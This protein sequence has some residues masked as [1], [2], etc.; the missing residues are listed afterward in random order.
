MLSTVIEISSSEED[1]IV[2]NLSKKPKVE[3]FTVHRVDGDGHCI[4]NC[5]V[6]FLKKDKNEILDILWN[7]FRENVNT[8]IQFGEYT[9]TNELLECLQEYVH[10]RKYNQ[11][12]VDLVLEALSKVFLLRIFIFEGSLNNDPLGVI[13]E[14][15]TKCIN[16]IKS[17]DH[18]NLVVSSTKTNDKRLVFMLIFVPYFYTFSG[19]L[20]QYTN[21][22]AV[23]RNLI[24]RAGVEIG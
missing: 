2:E 9:S 6:T 12:T 11:D 18:Y 4:I 10:N 20:Q 3:D 8:Y 22:H 17:G 14:K 5:F 24:F 23:M 21:K 7:E 13:G 1:E 15:F 16:L 19:P